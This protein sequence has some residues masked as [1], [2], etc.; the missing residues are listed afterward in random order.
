MKGGALRVSRRLDGLRRTVR[1]AL[2]L[3]GGVRVAVVGQSMHPT[4][5]DGDRLLVS[6]MAYRRRRPRRGEI[7]LLRARA[8]GARNPESIKR[9]VGLPHERVQ[10]VA[11]EV[12]LDGRS[13][14]EPYLARPASEAE[15]AMRA[16]ALALRPPCEWRLGA[17][18][19]IVLGDNRA[20]STDSRAFGPLRRR[21]IVGR[22]WYRYA[23]RGRAGRPG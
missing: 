6:R 1:V 14:P 17:D 2:H 8:G 13:L 7:V 20:R 23:P 19:Y 18:E 4:L 11:G 5:R 10:V 3:L 21:D 9:I 12:H 15:R 16:A 22:A